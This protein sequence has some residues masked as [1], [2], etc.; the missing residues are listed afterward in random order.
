MLMDAVHDSSQINLEWGRSHH[1]TLLDSHPDFERISIWSTTVNTSSHDMK[2]EGEVDNFLWAAKVL[3]D[4]LEAS[5]LIELK[6]RSG[7]VYKA[8]K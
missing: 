4:M 5:W 6:V 3:Q 8:K 2:E 1:T 7:Q